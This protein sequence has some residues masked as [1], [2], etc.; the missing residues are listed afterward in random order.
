ML[1]IRNE[2]TE[3]PEVYGERT[4]KLSPQMRKVYFYAFMTA[5]LGV[6]VT[7]TAIGLTRL[8]ALIH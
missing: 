1:N 8:V 3:R 4:R 5:G 2:N 6:G 7:L